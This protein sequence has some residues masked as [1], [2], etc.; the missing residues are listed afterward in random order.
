MATDDAAR[1]RDCPKAGPRHA[2]PRKTLLARLHMPAGKAV[3]LAAMPTAVLMGMGF[4]PQLASAKPTEPGNPLGD[5]FCLTA[6]DASQGATPSPG[7]SG[8]DAEKD[9][10][11]EKDKDAGKSKDTGKDKNKGKDKD[12][13]TKEPGEK[14]TPTPEDREDKAGEPG[15]PA[16][17]PS[18]SSGGT[19]D[20]AAPPAR[21]KLPELP[22]LPKLPPLPGPFTPPPAPTPT[23]TPTPT[24]T[25]T[26][27]P[28][29]GGTSAT[30]AP[31]ASPTPGASKD[32]TKDAEKAK[33]A[34][35]KAAEAEKKAKEAA[36]EKAAR[37][38]PG[39]TKSG[40]DARTPGPTPAT[41]D[42][43]SAP[44]TPSGTPSP[45][46]SGAKTPLPCPN[47]PKQAVKGEANFANNPWF[48]ESSKLTLT[49]L[50]YEGVKEVTTVNGQKKSVL[51]FTAD[52]LEI[53]K[54]HALVNDRGRVYHQ[55]GESTPSTVAGGKVTMYT[56]QLTGKL[57]GSSLPLFAANYSA[58]S[59]PP[60][61]PGM[62]LP[63]P[64]F[65]TDVK[66]RQ[67]GQ[68]GGTLTIPDMHVYITD[69]TYP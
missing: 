69:G 40:Q 56:E 35:R 12:E 22:P 53:A 16:E 23:P 51:K 49:G 63:I 67:A 28:S 58:S 48:L 55:S 59:P 38:A 66:I 25:P 2:A 57:F 17:E 54:L 9:K 47:P 33:E 50:T 6:P 64:L 15:K 37:P 52:K 7:A 21:G 65:F 14:K 44:A 32:A 5:A 62:K 27:T 1:D 3:A 31:P 39:P 60:L 19:D 10:E 11:A 30:P 4:T 24:T 29:P 68:F 42:A 61:I 18:P 8:K 13:P 34:A 26:P 43:P 46:A 41:P 36:A 45:G 20:P